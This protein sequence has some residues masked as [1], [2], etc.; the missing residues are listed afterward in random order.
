MHPLFFFGWKTTA[1][2]TQYHFVDHLRRGCQAQPGLLAATDFSAKFNVNGQQV[3]CSQNNIRKRVEMKKL[4]PFPRQLGM[5]TVMILLLPASF[6]VAQEEAPAEGVAPAIERIVGT[7][8]VDMEQTK[9]VMSEEHFKAISE[10]SEGDIILTFG[11]DGNMTRKIA[12]DLPQETL[13]FTIAAVEGEEDLYSMVITDPNRELKGK[14]KFTDANTI[15]IMPEGEE[16]A[17]LVRVV[18]E[19]E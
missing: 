4:I 9:E 13:P 17:I 6:V 3:R 14:V 7:W 2:F 15:K 10:A 16:P 11:E 12:V 19:D 5:L 1:R 8:K 18:E